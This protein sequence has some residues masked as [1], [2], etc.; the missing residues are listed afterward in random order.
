MKG[1]IFY[2][3]ACSKC[4]QALALLEE[5]QVELDVV[6]YLETPPTGA[7]LGELIAKLDGQPASLVRT[8]DSKFKAAGL[9]LADDASSDDVVS[10]LLAHPEVMQR[11]VVVRDE[12]AV[13]ARPPERVD[14]LF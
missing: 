3:G 11:P 13:V 12:R 6:H 10:L 9:S 5:K 1:T 7:Q 14:E 4:R 8:S 2:N